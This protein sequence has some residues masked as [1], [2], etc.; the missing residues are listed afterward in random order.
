MK[1]PKRKVIRKN[2]KD[3]KNVCDTEKSKVHEFLLVRMRV[4]ALPAKFFEQQ[5]KE[6]HKSTEILKIKFSVKECFICFVQNAEK[7]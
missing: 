7:K 1:F 5:R 3:G 2:R 6:R 4:A